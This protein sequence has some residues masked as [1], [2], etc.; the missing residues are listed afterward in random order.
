MKEGGEAENFANTLS[1]LL[2]SLR[3]YA[4]ERPIERGD[5]LVTRF[6]IT[7]NGSIISQYQIDN[8]KVFKSNRIPYRII[9][10]LNKKNCLFFFFVI[11]NEFTQ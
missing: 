10:F 6:Q 8:Q 2:P 9:E 4:A 5:I 3:I 11:K 1:V 7:P